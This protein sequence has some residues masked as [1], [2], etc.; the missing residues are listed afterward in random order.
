MALKTWTIELRVDF[1]TAT[2][3]QK[4]KIMLKAVCAM[5]KQLITTATLIAD[6]RKPDIS[7]QTD[8]MFAGRASVEMF[9]EDDDSTL[10]T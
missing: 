4:N 8:D 3:E 7:I 9:D 6:K 2:Q 10:P 1:D 5:A